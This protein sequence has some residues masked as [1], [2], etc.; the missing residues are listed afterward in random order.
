MRDTDKIHVV[1]HAMRG[2]PIRG[3]VMKGTAMGDTLMRGFS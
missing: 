2:T 3:T 1:M